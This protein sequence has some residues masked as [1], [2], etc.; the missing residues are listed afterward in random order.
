MNKLIF[1]FLLSFGAQAQTH[2]IPFPDSNAIWVQVKAKAYP[3]GQGPDE[4]CPYI[5]YS[6]DQY[7]NGEHIYYNT[8]ARV[9]DPAFDFMFDWTWDGQSFDELIGRFRVDGLKVYYQNLPH[10]YIGCLA[11]PTYTGYCYDSNCDEEFLMYDFGLEVGDTFNLTSQD[12]IL[13]E[14]IDSILI[15]GV[16]YRRF[17]FEP[18]DWY[19]GPDYYWIEGIGSSWGFFPYFEPFEQALS[20]DCFQEDP[21]NNWIYPKF[22]YSHSGKGCQF[23]GLNETSTKGSKTLVRITDAMGRECPDQPNICL[24]HYYSDGSID[25]VFRME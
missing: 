1:L 20:F 23:L 15:E 11:G 10:S 14:S 3:P 19:A 7:D 13:L 9:S 12:Q 22:S 25:R 5:I 4:Y 2:E 17:N 24:I 18:L 21:L 6:Y 16:Y 8:Y